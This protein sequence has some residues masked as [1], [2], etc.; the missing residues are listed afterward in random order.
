M[1]H[2]RREP[3]GQSGSEQ[4]GVVTIG[5]NQNLVEHCINNA[6]NW[7]VTDPAAAGLDHA[8][9]QLKKYD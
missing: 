8:V 1:L 6:L 9:N 3:A 5:D 7:L 2:Y 4:P